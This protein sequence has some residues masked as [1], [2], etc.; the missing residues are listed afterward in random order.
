MTIERAMEISNIISDINEI[1]TTIERIEKDDRGIM[2]G[3]TEIECPKENAVCSLSPKVIYDYNSFILINRKSNLHVTILN[4]L[5][6][7]KKRLE[8][9]IKSIND[10]NDYY[11]ADFSGHNI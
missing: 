7:E 3:A 1:N 6:R 4:A 10:E 11:T 8:D 2:I 5:Q 9:K